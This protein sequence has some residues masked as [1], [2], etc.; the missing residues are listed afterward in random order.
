MNKKV[1]VAGLIIIVPFLV[2]LFM[3]LGRD[4]HEIES[5]LIGRIAPQFAL[6]EVGSSRAVPLESL[7]GRP[8]VINFWATW[9]VPCFEEHPIL[10]SSA[11]A[12]GD[13][14]QFLGVVY[15][16]EEPR[17]LKFLSENGQSYPT[18]FDDGG[19]TAIAYGVY[20]VPETFF[21]DPT[22]KIVAKHS[23]PL[24]P[25]A[26]AANVQLAMGGAR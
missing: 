6:R 8:A 1:L 23:G 13:R 19:K 9:C 16:D 2:I 24:T 3:N 17:I 20:G 11:A 4:P 15:Q 21:L 18:L 26:L 22:G 25:Q 12:Y 5:P 10:V 14:V 7:R